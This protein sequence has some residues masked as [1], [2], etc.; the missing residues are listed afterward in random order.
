MNVLIVS[1]SFFPINSPRSFRTTELVKELCRLGHQVTLYTPK[2]DYDYTEYLKD[3]PIN[4]KFYKRVEERRK[5]LGISIIDRMIFRFLNQFFA[6]PTIGSYPLLKQSLK[7][8]KNYDLLIT[9][10]V[11]H[12]IPW[13]FGKLYADGIRAAKTWISDC[14]DPF[15]LAHSGNYRP[16][17]YLKKLEKRWCEYCDYI[18]VPTETSYLGYYPEFRNKI[19]VIPQ[20][21]D[22]DAVKILEYKKNYIPTFAFAGSFIPGRRDPRKLF[23]YLCTIEKPFKF[24]VYGTSDKSRWSGILSKLEG[25]VFFEKPIPRAELLPKLSQMDFLINIGNGTKVQTPSKLIDYTLAK[26]PILTIETNDIK[27]NILSEFLEGNYANQ[28]APID[29]SRY[30][31]HNVAQQ[32]LS[33]CR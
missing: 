28:D 14:G 33:L 8:E 25:K 2:T 4:M 16:P 21:F 29:I 24:F 17:L 18:S 20:G 12:S 31:I 1:G 11:P 5:F 15:M 7:G 19:R 23:E 9:I 32:F 6:Y 13:A 27:E 3:Y 26:R 10:A 30:D 22:F